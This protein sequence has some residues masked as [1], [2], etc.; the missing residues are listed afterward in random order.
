MVAFKYFACRDVT[1]LSPAIFT[2]LDGRV[3]AHKLFWEI[4]IIP[5]LELGTV[6]FLQYYFQLYL[7]AFSEIKIYGKQ[8]FVLKKN[9]LSN[10]NFHALLTIHVWLKGH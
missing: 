3:E 2:Q 1:S 6:N 9:L 4:L 5:W 8:F 7:Y 10:A